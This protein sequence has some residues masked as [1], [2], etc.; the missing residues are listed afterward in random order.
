MKK[1][2]IILVVFIFGCA[3]DPE[4]RSA[5]EN[6]DYSVDT[7][8]THDGCTVYRFDDAGK[9]RYFANCKSGQTSTTWAESCGKNCISDVAIQTGYGG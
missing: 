4:L 9:F 5:T 7:L 6:P 8:F 3:G 2:S 1:L